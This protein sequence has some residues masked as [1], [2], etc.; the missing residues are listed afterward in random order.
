MN[1]QMWAHPATRRNLA[2]LRA[3]GVRF[4]GPEP[5]RHGLRRGRLRPHGR[6]ARDPGRDRARC[7]AAAG[8]PL[9]GLQRARDQ[10]PDPRADRP[11]PLP[12]Q[13]LLRQAGPCHRRG[14]GRGRRRGHPGQRPGRRPPTR[15]A[16]RS[17]TSRRPARCWPPSRPPCRPTSPSSPPPSPTGARPRVPTERSRRRASVSADDRAG[18]EPRHPALRWRAMPTRRPRLVDRLCGGD[19]TTWRRMPRRSSRARAATGSSPTTSRR[20]R[21]SSAASATASCCSA[22]TARARR[23]PSWTRARWPG[24][25][26]RGSPRAGPGRAADG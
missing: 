8:R 18:R 15:P 1:P 5:G 9:A 16:S 3:D 26:S 23:G 13:P 12:R 2:R 17:V 22:A 19:R 24:G 14:P 21:A 20:A 6:A 11:R 4:V 7:C 10:R 25:W